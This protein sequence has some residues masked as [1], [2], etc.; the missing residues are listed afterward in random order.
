MWAF[1][2]AL[3]LT[4]IIVAS[5]A[6][7]GLGIFFS[8]GPALGI[9]EDVSGEIKSTDGERSRE[10]RAGEVDVFSAPRLIAG[11]QQG[12]TVTQELFSRKRYAEAELLLM[13]LVKVEPRV[14]ENHYNLA[15]AQALQ[16]KTAEALANLRVAVERGFRN[17]LHI[18]KDADLASLREQADFAAI[19]EEAAKPGARIEIQAQPPPRVIRDGVALVATDNTT[20]NLQLGTLVTSFALDPEDPR[21]QADAVAGQG[22]AGELVR[23]WQHEGTAV[24]LLGVLYDNH[25]RDHSDLHASDFPQLSF[26]EYSPEA[27][28]ES[29]DLGLQVRLIFNLPTIGNSSTAQTGGPL[30][31]SQERSAQT[32]PT[33]IAVQ[34][35]QYLSN[36][37]Y[38][39]PE[40]RDYDPGRNGGGGGWGDVFP[41]NT[42]YCIISQ[43]SSGSDQVFLRALA[44]TIAAF[45]PETYARLVKVRLLAPTLQ[46][47]LRRCYRPSESAEDYFTGRAHPVVFDGALLDVERMVVMAHAL[48]PTE[49]PPLVRLAVREEDA[50]GP[51][52]EYPD[53]TP[54]EVL[55]GTSCAVA[56]VWHG[57]ARTRR[58][59]V[60][61][62]GSVD[63][64]NRPMTYRWALLQG[65]REDVTISPLTPNG[66]VAE[67]RVAWH[68]RFAIS[69]ESKLASNR[70]DIGVFASGGG[71]W[72]APAFV[73]FYF[74]DNQ[75][76]HYDEAGRLQSIENRSF[77][78]GGNYADPLAHTPRDWRD[79]LRYDATGHLLGWRRTRGAAAE[80]FTADGHLVIEKDEFGRAIRACAVQYTT[81][82]HPTRGPSIRQISTDVEYRYEYFS[83]DD[84]RGRSIASREPPDGAA[85]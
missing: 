81:D 66:S 19:L 31:R 1:R 7:V 64:D 38:V 62:E 56:R 65:N 29:M 83:P 42:P 16:G 11:M 85:R 40:H 69:P 68:S 43:G 14:A 34:A 9:R 78:K 32:T 26:I 10:L 30:W 80:D 3:K 41:A 13:E 12:S 52:A 45:R 54:G 76:R 47:I 49:I 39:Y 53:A 58:L 73:T 37:L 22:R 61:V 48:S 59:I 51:G 71:P 77:A 27:R 63:L 18:E 74:P 44:T 23:Q 57:G 84:Q 25:D 67:L 70:V 50:A 60:N 17:P 28:R 15:C 5:I 24:G 36:L 79:D 35:A 8:R 4:A 2:S 6:L 20:V 75:T 82:N 33:A 55:F 72:S 21:R 46:M